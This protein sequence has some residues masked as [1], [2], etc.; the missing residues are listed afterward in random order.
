VGVG[1]RFQQSFG[2]VDVKAYG[3]YETAGKDDLTTI[4]SMTPA[5]VRAAPAG[6]G[7][8]RYNNLSFCKFGAAVTAMIFTLAPTISGSP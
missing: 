3:F 1:L 7:P 2:A 5:T 8:L 6:A 4:A